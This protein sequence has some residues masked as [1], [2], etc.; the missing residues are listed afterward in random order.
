MKEL[1][2]RPWVT[3]LVGVWW[4]TC[5]GWVCV[6]IVPVDTDTDIIDITCHIVI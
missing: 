1:K 2:N 3:W 6:V 4:V 5:D